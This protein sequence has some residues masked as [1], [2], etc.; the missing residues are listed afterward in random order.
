METQGFESP[1]RYQE[2]EMVTAVIGLA[3]F[4]TGAVVGI[5]GYSS[6]LEYEIW[7]NF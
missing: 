4:A 2:E 1:T 3:A 5:F 7:K 6:W